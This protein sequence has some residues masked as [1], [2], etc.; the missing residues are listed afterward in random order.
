MIKVFIMIV[1]MSGTGKEVEAIEFSTMEN[2][3]SAQTA[4]HKEHKKS[5]VN[6]WLP[7]IV[8]VEK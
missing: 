2:C 7:T 4:I 6:S 3:V 8:C 5:G 1:I